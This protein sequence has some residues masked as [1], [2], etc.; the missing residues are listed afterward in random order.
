MKN[1]REGAHIDG[2]R[3]GRNCLPKQL[4]GWG[5][6]RQTLPQRLLGV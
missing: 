6:L 1:K 2:V 4:G 5:L 3:G